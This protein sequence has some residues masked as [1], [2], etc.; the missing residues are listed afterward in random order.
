MLSKMGSS[1]KWEWKDG[2]GCKR[3]KAI[4]AIP[5]SACAS[6]LFLFASLITLLTM[7]PLAVIFWPF[8]EDCSREGVGG[9]RMEI[10]KAHGRV[11]QHEG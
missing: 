10:D 3:P 2:A 6:V 1:E 4:H 5:R 8:S 9:K 11:Q 7:R